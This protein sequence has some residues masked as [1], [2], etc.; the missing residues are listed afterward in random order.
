MPL[1]QTVFNLRRAVGADARRW[2]LGRPWAR[3][4]LHRL[5]LSPLGHSSLA[6]IRDDGV[7][8]TRAVFF[9][10]FAMNYK[11]AESEYRFRL[12]DRDGACLGAWQQRARPNETLVVESREVLDRLGVRPPF[13]GT[14]GAEVQHEALFPPR[15]L[16]ANI[17]YYSDDGFVSTVH[18]QGRYVRLP[19]TTSQ[20]LVHVLE[21]EV[22]ETAVVLQNGYRYRRDPRE[23]MA[24]ATIDLF[25]RQGDKRTAAVA[26]FPA[27]GMRY[28]RLRELF[29]DAPSF[30]G[31]EAGGLRIR[32]NAPIP[33][34]IPVIHNRVTGDYSVNHTGGD[35]ATDLSPR[36][37]LAE[38]SWPA[39][40]WAPVWSGLVEERDDFHTAFSIF[41]HFVPRDVYAVDLRLYDNAG[42]LIKTLPEIVTFGPN[43]TRVLTM[44]PILREHGIA[45][46]FRGTAAMRLTP[47]SDGRPMPGDGMFKVNIL[48]FNDRSL[49]LH[50]TQDYLVLNSLREAHTL[51]S[52]RRTRIFGRVVEND[53]QETLL[54]LTNFSSDDDY[55]VVSDTEIIVFD[56]A[57]E[58]SLKARLSI[59]PQTSALV[60]LRDLFPTVGA[61]LASSAGVSSALVVDSKVKIHGAVVLRNKLTGGLGADHLFG[62]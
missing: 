20:T 32:S 14:L 5:G 11:L 25:N 24:T 9:N 43:E 16:R 52:P 1:R 45:P 44:E 19:T 50:N 54:G 56:A 55:D 34:T 46:P 15:Y 4:R 13:D 41:N 28:V 23:F 62:G 8:H 49:A 39:A 26:P 47:K 60:G 7:F 6:W 36:H 27:C 58:R 61:F 18:D 21:D 42:K 17:D 33:R 22:H 10:Y 48:Y 2:L 12:F 40:V 59:A 3:R 38:R 51:S 35:S 57:G 29:P 31:G 53:I 30:L 37:V